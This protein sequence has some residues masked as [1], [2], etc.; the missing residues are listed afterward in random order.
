MSVEDIDRRLDDRFAL[1]RGGDRSAPDRHQTLL[2]VIDWSW[3]LLA[4]RR[5]AGAALAVGL[6]RRL[7]ARRRRAVLGDDALDA[8]AALV[9]QSLLTVR[10]R[11]ADACA[12]GCSRRCASS[13]GCSSSRPAR[14]RA[15]R[16]AQLGLGRARSPTALGDDLCRPDQVDA[17]RAIAREENNLADVP[18]RG[19]RR[20]A[21]RGRRSAAGRAGRASGPSAARPPAVI[22]LAARGRRRAGRLGAAAGR[23]GRRRRV[24]PPRSS[25]ST[26]DRR[27]DRDAPPSLA[28]ARRLRRAATD[29]GPGAL[30]LV[31]GRQG[32]GR[33][34]TRRHAGAGSTAVAER[35]T[36]RPS[37]MARLWAAHHLEN[38][39]DPTGAIA[40]AERGAGPG[41]ATPTARGSRRCCTPSARPASTP[42]S[43]TR[44]GRAR[45]RARRCPVLDRLEATDD[46]IQTRALLAVPRHVE[47]RLDEAERAGSPRSSG[48][49]TQRS[50]F[51][52]ASSSAPPAPSWRWPGRR[53]SEG[54]RA[55]PRRRRGAGRHHAS[56]AWA[57]PPASSRGP[58]S[59]RAAGVTALRRARRTRARRGRATSSRRCCAKA[60]HGARPGPSLPGLPGRRAWCCRARRLGA[61]DA[62]RCRPRT[63]SGC[64]C[65]PS[66][67]PT[68]QLH[69]TMGPARTEASRRA[70]SRPALAARLRGGVRRAHRARTCL[71]EAR[72]VARAG[73][74]CREP[75]SCGV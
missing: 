74:P 32:A 29:R 43:A 13:A 42:S 57:T 36:A 56:R 14:T 8:V 23:A 61:A 67:S 16:D 73:S 55:L 60:P 69:P 63:P 47:G 28:A 68:P 7:L 6:P 65:S 24:A 44:G 48:D 54:L 46:A 4:R 31:A 52:G 5:A 3:N 41:R 33:S 39:G 21:T 12:T 71:P 18:A 11:G 40:E 27:R 58:C 59:A 10:R 72:A 50:G 49:S 66:G 75:T 38:N 2:A 45:T 19:A 22:A 70:R 37:A 26:R 34:G 17:V 15:A 53:S 64:S 30:A 62:T 1:L 20:A 35:P 9:D 25:R 51:G